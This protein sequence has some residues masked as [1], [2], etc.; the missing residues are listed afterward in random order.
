MKAFAYKIL[1]AG[2]LSLTASVSWASLPE[3]IANKIKQAGFDESSVSIVVEPLGKQSV[4]KTTKISHQADVMRVPAS[5]QKLIATAAALD[6]LGADYR[7][8]TSVY[9][10]GLTVG[11]VLYGDLIIRGSG[12]PSMTHTQLA[13]LLQSIYAKGITH[14]VGD[15]VIDDRAFKDVAFD[16]A[17]FDGQATRAYNASPDAFLVNFGTL[18]IDILPAVGEK[19]ALVQVLPRLAEFDVP[20]SIGANDGKCSRSNEPSISLAK[21]KLT[22]QGQIGTECGRVSKWVAYPDAK[23]LATKAVKGEWKKIDADFSGQVRLLDE[24]Q[25]QALLKVYDYRLPIVHHF[26]RPLSEQVKDINH[27]SNN[28]MTEQVALSLPLAKGAK[29][30][31]YPSAFAFIDQWW[32]QHIS[33]PAPKMSRASGLCRDCQVSASS[34]ASLLKY[35]YQSDF[36][37]GYLASLPIA[38]QSGTMKKFADRNPDS[39]AIG[40]AWL[41]TG[42][43][44]DVAA[45]A[46]YAKDKQDRWYVL[47]AIINAPSAG[48]SDQALAVLDEIIIHTTAQGDPTQTIPVNADNQTVQQP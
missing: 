37:D 10:H 13:T 31:D 28:V 44:A 6:E 41:K 3:N 36:F 48:F 9:Q 26:S 2:V 21:D 7:W 24:H 18:E 43:L 45:V 19:T 5:T 29:V 47:V 38:G 27:F 11:G 30:S 1:V 14:I 4:E 8:T 39:P 42:T 46:G 20:T 33:E 16:T 22:L 34:L 15:I 32:R 40:R 23:L 17:A 12:D 25:D 35:A